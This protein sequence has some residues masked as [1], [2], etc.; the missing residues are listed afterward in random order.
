MLYNVDYFLI[1]FS[2][3]PLTILP[4]S[5]WN[6]G[7]QELRREALL[8]LLCLSNCRVGNGYPASALGKDARLS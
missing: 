4:L 3:P 2:F 5:F 6:E 8:F 1:R 7:Y